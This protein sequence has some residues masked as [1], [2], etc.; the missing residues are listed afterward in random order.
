[1]LSARGTRELFREVL[2]QEAVEQL[3]QLN[4]KLIQQIMSITNI[5]DEARWKWTSSKQFSVSLY[6]LAFKHAPTFKAEVSKVW[7][8]KAPPRMQVFSWLMMLNKILTIDNL[9]KRGWNMVNRCI[10]CKSQLE[11]VSHLFEKCT[12]TEE[13]YRHI[14][15]TMR[16][17]IP[18]R[19]ARKA[20]INNE[21]SKEERSLLQITQFV[22]WRERCSRVFTDKSNSN[23]LLIQQVRDQWNITMQREGQALT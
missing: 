12:V 5:P 1:M 19:Q 17:K 15:T 6:Y 7:K 16:M 14:S 8:T 11:T 22:I 9:M 4:E 21:L 23:D 20:L 3:L 10:M 13:I 18:I 2:S